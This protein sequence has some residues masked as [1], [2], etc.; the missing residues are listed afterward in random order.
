[1]PLLCVVLLALPDA[2]RT[3]TLV[4]QVPTTVTRPDVAALSARTIRTCAFVAA[5]S[6][7]IPNGTPATSAEVIDRFVQALDRT[8]PTISRDV[9]AVVTEA[10][11]QY[12]RDMVDGQLT[13]MTEELAVLSGHSPE[14]LTTGAV[15]RALR[16]RYADSRRSTRPASRSVARTLELC[17][18]IEALVVLRNGFNSAALYQQLEAL[19]SEQ[20]PYASY[21]AVVAQLAG[22]G[23]TAALAWS[24]IGFE[25]QRHIN[26]VWHQAN[27]LE[28]LYP[29]RDAADMLAL[30]WLGL[31]TALRLYDPT[32]GFSFSTY[33]CTR[34]TGSIRDGVRAENPVPK[35]LG[36]FGRKVAAAEEALAHTL[37]RSPTLDE[38]AAHLGVTL[39]ELKIMPRLQNAAS[40][41]EME[42][43][44]SERGGPASWLVDNTDPADLAVHALRREAVES[45]LGRLDPDDAAAVRLLVMEGLRPAEAHTI[46][47]EA[48]RRLRARRERALTLLRAE[49]GDWEDGRPD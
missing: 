41:E 1:V 3:V 37:G 16:Q 12:L 43:Y 18:R 42:E 26:L 33:A 17:T 4:P 25:S 13:P 7:Q 14:L 11:A 22:L 31:R 10:A 40:I 27:K 28:R 29:D 6:E 36:T 24:V 38:V 2:A 9:R 19:W 5:L 47:G 48:P 35:R 45:A 23:D 49:L 34:I 32:L 39:D 30:G 46:T 15:L 8:G 44:L 21:D 20:H